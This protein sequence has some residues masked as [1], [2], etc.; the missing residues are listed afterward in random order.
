M[1][2]HRIPSSKRPGW[3]E[4]LGFRHMSRRE[5]LCAFYDQFGI[6]PS[7]LHGHGTCTSVDALAKID[8]HHEA[9]SKRTLLY[10]ASQG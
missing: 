8:E 10:H 4:V 2:A 9:L 7:F 5:G 6:A 3:N 1:F